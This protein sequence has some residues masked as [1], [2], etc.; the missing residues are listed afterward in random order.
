MGTPCAPQLGN[1]YMAYCEQIVV[2]MWHDD[3]PK[4]YA[5]HRF[6]DDLFGIVD[7]DTDEAKMQQQWDPAV[8]TGLPN[9]FALT[10]EWSHSSAVFMDVVIHKGDRF[11]RTGVLDFKLYTKPINRFLY[12]PYKTGHPKHQL[13]GFIKGE[14]QRFVRNNSNRRDFCIAARRFFRHLRNRGYPDAMLRSAWPS[15]DFRNREQYLL[16]KRPTGVFPGSSAATLAFIVYNNALTRIFN[17]PRRWQNL[18]Q[19][20]AQDM[21]RAGRPI[22]RVVAQ[23]LTNSLWKKLAP[24]R[25]PPAEPAVNP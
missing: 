25:R 23:K 13:T 11:Q 2:N 6:Q 12:I 24:L 16:D 1:L 14:L 15:V 18:S 7:A 8:N 9:S 19:N 22:N 17:L 4:L 20:V 3:A 21:R 10:W 5:Y